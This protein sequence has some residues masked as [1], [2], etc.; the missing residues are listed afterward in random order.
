M[1]FGKKICQNSRK[2]WSNRILC[3]LKNRNLARNESLTGHSSCATKNFWNFFMKICSSHL[4]ASF[5]SFSPKL[6]NCSRHSESLNIRKNFEIDDIYLRRQLMS[7]FRHTLKTH[8][9]SNNG[10]ILAQ[11]VPKEA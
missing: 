10:P 1:F 5:D 3:S 11:K 2:K 9:A 8:C 4:Y 7:I 6:V